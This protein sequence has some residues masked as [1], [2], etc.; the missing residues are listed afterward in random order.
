MFPHD[1][2]QVLEILGKLIRIK[3]DEAHLLHKPLSK[4]KLQFAI[5]HVRAEQVLGLMV[6]SKTYPAEKT[7]HVVLLVHISQWE[8][9]A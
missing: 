9:Q 2:V 5:L 4:H 6:L 3:L 7:E 8:M 1:P